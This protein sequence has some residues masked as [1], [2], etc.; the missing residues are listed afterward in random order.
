MKTFLMI[1]AAIIL[2][3]I[4]G[5]YY[6]YNSFTYQPDYFEQIE[7]L[8]V[9]AVNVQTDAITKRITKEL[10]ETGK[11]NLDG[12]ELTLLVLNQLEDMKD[13]EIKPS[14][15]KLKSEI[16]NGR[17]EVESIVDVNKLTQVELPN[18]ADNLIEQFLQ[19]I[20]KDMMSEVYVSFDGIPMDRKGMLRIDENSVISVGD[21]SKKL[22]ELRGNK[23]FEINSSVLKQLGISS[24]KVMDDHIELSR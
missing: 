8:D 24:F 12:N 15:K 4:I 9:Q 7:L 5:V 6:L 21:F 11:A 22:S 20:P 19:N 23:N 2:I 13:V 1:V 16:K 10:K 14:I 17:L 3:A 18:G